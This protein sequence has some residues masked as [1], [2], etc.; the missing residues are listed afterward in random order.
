MLGTFEIGA[1]SRALI[2]LCIT[3]QTAWLCAVIACSLLACRVLTCFTSAFAAITAVAVT[4][5]AFAAFTV[6]GGATAL[7]GRVGLC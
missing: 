1:L 3:A 7:C 4:R 5:A 6:F 2:C